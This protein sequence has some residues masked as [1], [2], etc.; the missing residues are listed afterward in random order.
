MPDLLFNVFAIFLSFKCVEV[1]I[2]RYVGACRYV[3]CSCGE[4]RVA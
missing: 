2:C 4:E 3:G 1:G